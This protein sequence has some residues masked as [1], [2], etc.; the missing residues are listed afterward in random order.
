[1]REPRQRAHH[2]PHL[3]ERDVH[4]GTH[5]ARVELRPC[6][7]CELGAGLGRAGRLLVRARRGD[8]VVDVGDRDDASGEWDLLSGDATRVALAV[9][10]LVVVPDRVGPRAQPFV[11]GLDERLAVQGMAAQLLPFLVRRL[12][13]LVQDLGADVELADVVEERG[14]IQ[15]VELLSCQAELLAE[16]VGVGADALGVSARDLVVDVERPCQL[17]QNLRGLLRTRRLV[18]PAQLMQPLLEAL[19]GA[20]P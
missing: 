17:E 10:V 4:E 5:E 20:R 1:M 8:H 13:G 3:A 18:G 7:A 14:P 15:T 6:T 16:A 2:E 19:D 9:P 12:A 11:E